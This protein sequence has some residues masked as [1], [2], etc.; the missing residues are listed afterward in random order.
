MN[1][2]ITP[3]RRWALGIT[4]I[5]IFH[6]S[7]EALVRSGVI[8]PQMLPTASAVFARYAAEFANPSFYV[9]LG[10]TL[11]RFAGGLA[12]SICIAVPLGLALGYSSL[13]YRMFGL[14]IEVLRPIPASSL[15]PART[16]SYRWCSRWRCSP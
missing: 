15:L 3:A 6:A 10:A 12:V 9:D 7:W 11:S 5:F 2:E 1:A 14:T 16:C 8:N 4:T 13:L